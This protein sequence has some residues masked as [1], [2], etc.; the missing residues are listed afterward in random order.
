[1]I[2]TASGSDIEYLE[3]LGVDEVVDYTRERFEDK[4]TGIDAVVDL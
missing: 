2:G 4:A 3:S 1:V